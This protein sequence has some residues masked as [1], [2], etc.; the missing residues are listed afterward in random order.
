MIIQTTMTLIHGQ[1]AP[2]VTSQRDGLFDQ[3]PVSIGLCSQNNILWGTFLHSPF[4]ESGI[5]CE[6]LGFCI[7]DSWYWII[8][9]VSGTWIPDP[10]RSWD[11]GFLELYC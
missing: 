4:L 7:P 2:P 10:I 8:V 6:S 5:H 11:S 3:Q 1:R 9:F